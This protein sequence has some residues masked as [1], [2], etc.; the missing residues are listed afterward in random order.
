[1]ENLKTV[2]L[3]LKKPFLLL[4]Q[5]ICENYG[6]HCSGALSTANRSRVLDILPVKILEGIGYL[7]KTLSNKKYTFQLEYAHIHINP[8]NPMMAGWNRYQEIFDQCI[9]L[10]AIEL[11]LVTNDAEFVTEI[12]PKMSEANQEIWKANQGEILFNEN[13]QMKVAKESRVTW[14]FHFH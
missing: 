9:N 2:E 7:K 8:S 11:A 10:K 12:F 14:T 1:M 13:L 3:R 5:H 4:C 6:K